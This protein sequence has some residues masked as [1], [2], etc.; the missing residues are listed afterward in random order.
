MQL[1]LICLL[2]LFDSMGRQ[3][4]KMPSVL[5]GRSCNVGGVEQA[6]DLAEKKEKIIFPLKKPFRLVC[7]R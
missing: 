1:G 5:I 2:T 6:D 4:G 7:N 3:S